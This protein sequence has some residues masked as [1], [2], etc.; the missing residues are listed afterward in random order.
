MYVNLCKPVLE[1]GSVLWMTEKALSQEFFYGIL[2]MSLSRMPD[3]RESATEAPQSRKKPEGTPLSLLPNKAKKETIH[4]MNH[5]MLEKKRPEK[6]KMATPLEKITTE[7][8]VAN[9]R[10]TEPFIKVFNYSG[11]NVAASALGTLVG[12]LEV[13]ERSEDSAYIVNFLASVAKKEYFSNPRRGA[14][15]S[16][17]AALHKI[18]LALAE[19][20]KHGN[21][22][23]LGKLHG[24]LGI[25]EKNNFHF[26]V[27]GEA[28][29]L[30]LRNGTFSSISEGLASDESFSPSH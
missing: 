5:G 16:L 2:K 21:I 17:E 20:V 27:T 1:A 24:T 6:T 19:L 18:N 11:E 30:L 29:I 10:A 3:K 7:I 23:W 9:G 14:I 13:A 25:L 12:V 4:F 22:A 15:E 26:S 8:Q 28:N